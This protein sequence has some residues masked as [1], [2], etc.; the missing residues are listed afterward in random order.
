MRGAQG[1]K[2][3][4]HAHFVGPKI[5]ITDGLQFNV[6][7]AAAVSGL[8]N[9]LLCTTLSHLAALFVRPLCQRVTRSFWSVNDLKSPKTNCYIV[10]YSSSFH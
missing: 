4:D 1:A 7:A 2:K 6:Q 8:N 5:V 9:T 10:S 3:Q